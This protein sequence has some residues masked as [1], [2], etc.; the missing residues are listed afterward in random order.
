MCRVH[1][2][3]VYVIDVGQSVNTIH[4]KWRD[5]LARDVHN[6]MHYFHHKR[7]IRDVDEVESRTLEYVLKEESEEGANQFIAY[8][9][10]HIESCV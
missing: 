8:I 7:E 1:H 9:E 4:D 6:I 2:G 10:K 3:R 5:F